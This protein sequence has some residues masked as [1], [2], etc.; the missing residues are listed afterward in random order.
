MRVLVTGGA[1]Y[2]GSTTAERLVGTGHEVVV[3]DSLVRGHRAAVPAEAALV[4][5]DIGDGATF[6]KA[7]RDHQIEAVLHC[8]G[9][10]VVGESVTQ[11]DRYF[12]VNV[13]S[14]PKTIIDAVASG[15]RAAASIHEYLAGVT[16]GERAIFATVRYATAPEDR[17]ILD[18]SKRPR[19]HAPLPMIQAGTFKATQVGFDEPTARAEAGRCF[20]CRKYPAAG[21][22]F[23]FD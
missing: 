7:L 14:G 15:R 2:V 17:L 4:V 6:E 13:V 9:L 20:R 5:G 19:A 16:D 18:L 11:P 22:G 21:T 1:G 12:E 10:A 23:P 8:G 3:Y